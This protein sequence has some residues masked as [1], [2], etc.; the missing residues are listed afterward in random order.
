MVYI[1]NMFG[2]SDG[3]EPSLLHATAECRQ[4]RKRIKRL[5]REL[6]SHED[7]FYFYLKTTENRRKPNVRKRKDSRFVS[8]TR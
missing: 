6:E 1:K 3:D 4:K 2:G 7:R 5:R 8:G